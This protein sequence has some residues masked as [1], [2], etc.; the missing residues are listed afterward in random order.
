VLEGHV[1][2]LPDAEL[3]AQVGQ[4]HKPNSPAGKAETTVQLFM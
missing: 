3:V 1:Y 4:E 2:R